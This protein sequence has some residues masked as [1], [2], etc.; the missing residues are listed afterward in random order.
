MSSRPPVP[1]DTRPSLLFLPLDIHVLLFE[2]LSPS[3]ISKLRTLSHASY[4][5]FTSPAVCSHYLSRHG[6][7]PE[8]QDSAKAEFDSY[9]RPRSRIR[10]GTPTRATIIDGLRLTEFDAPYF[11]KSHAYRSAGD[12]A[13]RDGVVAYRTA[14]GDLAL[15]DLSNPSNSTVLLINKTWEFTTQS[16][17]EY[18]ESGAGMI[19][20]EPGRRIK[21]RISGSWWPAESFES[22]GIG[23]RKFEVN[24]HNDSEGEVLFIE[25]S[26]IKDEKVMDPYDVVALLSAAHTPLPS[27]EERTW[28]PIVARTKSLGLVISLKPKSFGHPLA[29]FSLPLNQFPHAEYV[30]NSYY[31]TGI[32]P[33]TQQ[34]AFLRYSR[35]DMETVCAIQ[36]ARREGHG[37]QLFWK[38]QE[39]LPAVVLIDLE[40]M[41][42]S[43]FCIPF[44]SRVGSG[45]NSDTHVQQDR[46]GE[47][48]FIIT[49]TGVTAFDITRMSQYGG[50]NAVKTYWW[51]HQDCMRVYAPLDEDL[52][53]EKMERTLSW[54]QLQ[55]TSTRTRLGSDLGSKLI[56]PSVGRIWRSFLPGT[57]FGGGD[58]DDEMFTIVRAYNY[59]IQ[60]VHGKAPS[61]EIH[62]KVPAW[63]RPEFLVAWEIP[64]T[65]KGLE[66]YSSQMLNGKAGF[67]GFKDEAPIVDPDGNTKFSYSENPEGIDPTKIMRLQTALTRN[68]NSLL[69]ASESEPHLV[70][71]VHMPQRTFVKENRHKTMARFLKI[72][73][74]GIALEGDEFRELVGPVE[75]GRW[76][77]ERHHA[78]L[79]KLPRRQQRDIL[80]INCDIKLLCER[81]YPR[82]IRSEKRRSS[83]MRG[84][85]RGKEDNLQV[86]EKYTSRALGLETLP[87]GNIQHIKVGDSGS[88]I[89]YVVEVRPEQRELHGTL[90]G[91]LVIARYD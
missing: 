65:K 20:V 56:A 55:D 18:N 25:L 71:A 8:P 34:F 70:L 7:F 15:Y 10:K 84:F 60:V 79:L 50:L 12:N 69:A 43:K 6:I 61:E 31:I 75:R 27:E 46:A 9:F 1:N 57:V 49:G 72:N 17:A 30:L 76:T 3:D 41:G 14:A 62:T 58:G 68:L 86:L 88:Y 5:L 28:Y 74:Y 32:I 81:P 85:F 91:T 44:E 89:A 77:P 39:Y 45:N 87:R 24:I 11:T 40:K 73:D 2:Y 4:I 21:E 26:W 22:K 38:L 66:K 47:L 59:V 35:D 36:G 51:R 90:S 23:M 16:L 63:E 82:S 54:Q 78:G 53:Q 19:V 33:K 52:D 37:S 83:L 13:N 80:R 42:L 64:L 29:T 67:Q 48:V